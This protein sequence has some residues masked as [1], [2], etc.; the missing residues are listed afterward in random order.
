MSAGTFQLSKYETNAGG[1]C[2]CRVQPETLALTIESATN[3][4]P[5]DAVDQEAS[6]VMNGG[7]RR[8]GVNARS[9]SLRWTATHPT[10][11]DPNGIVRVPILKPSVWN[12]ISKGDTGTYLGSAVEVVGK[13]SE[14][15]N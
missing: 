10:G 9:V 8:I 6:A 13:S 1:I 11:Y 4:P 12:A 15:V 2:S 5:T 14:D 7:R 3:D